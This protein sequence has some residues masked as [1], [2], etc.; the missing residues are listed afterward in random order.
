MLL[1]PGGGKD[2]SQEG[3]ELD[4]SRPSKNLDILEFNPS[5]LLLIVLLLMVC[6]SLLRL[7]DSKFVANTLWT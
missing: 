5:R 2:N 1:P 3:A 4:P 6:L 7:A